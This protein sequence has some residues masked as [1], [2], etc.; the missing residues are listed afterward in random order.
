MAYIQPG[1][2]L[3]GT[4][5][6]DEEGLT[7]EAGI[8]KPLYVDERPQHKVSLAGYYIDKFEVT[9]VKYKKFIDATGHQ[10]PPYWNGNTYPQGRENHPVVMVSAEDAAKYCQWAGKRLP[11][12]AEWEKAAR[13]TDGRDYSWGNDFDL[14]K[15]NISEASH[16]AGNSVPVGTFKNDNSPYGVY[17]MVGNVHEWT[18]TPYKPYSDKDSDN[19]EFNRGYV[20]IRGNSWAVVGHYPEEFYPRICA[21]F[22]RVTYRYF[23]RPTVLLNDIGFRCVK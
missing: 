23:A 1:E 3:M 22:S 7:E 4:D 20:V 12:E 5:K 10:A 18:N 9:N 21:A 14:N 17:D 19:P 13:G 15:A 16:L 2:F 8:V 6:V 11:T